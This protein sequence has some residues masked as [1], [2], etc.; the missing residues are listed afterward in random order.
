MPHPVPLSP[1]DIA[2]NPDHFLHSFEGDRAI[3]VPM[4][5]VAYRR[6]I[7]LDQRISPAAGDAF[8][9]TA[10]VLPI[11][12]APPLGWIFHMAHCGSTLLARALGEL[13][14]NIVLRE[15]FALR[16]LAFDPDPARLALVTAMLARRY[17]PDAQTIVKANVPVN[18][19]L[20]QI[21]A[22]DPTA[23][24]IMLY[25]DLPDYFLA[26]LRSD[27]HRVWVRNV[28]TQ[29][30]GYLGDLTGL[31]DATRAA[32]LWLAQTRHFNAALAAMPNAR[33]LDA[34]QF[35]AKPGAA[36]FA[37]ARHL[38]VEA[39]PDAITALL[40]GPLFATYSKN[41][42]V[43]FDNQ[44]RIARRELLEPVLAEEIAEARRWLERAGVDIAATS[45]TIRSGVLDM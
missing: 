22:Q 41:P 29:L 30:S 3:I 7:F 21:T 38:Q 31:S 12:A 40:A 13:G 26:I 36:L 9:I 35:F 43:A 27:N 2:A 16:Q 25:C 8:A 28:T 24:A 34:E 19:L 18:F 39:T 6:S 14:E 45:S 20:P 32:A 17:D 23:R 44:A 4:D 37:A 11:P 10:A 15:P 42:A 1:A 5:A 33:S